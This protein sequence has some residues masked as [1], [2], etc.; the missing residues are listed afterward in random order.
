MSC[1]HKPYILALNYIFLCRKLCHVADMVE[2]RDCD[3]HHV[4]QIA[5]TWMLILSL[6]HHNS[7]HCDHQIESASLRQVSCWWKW[8]QFCQLAL[9]RSLLRCLSLSR[10]FSNTIKLDGFTASPA[11]IISGAT[12][13]CSVLFPATWLWFTCVKRSWIRYF[14]AP[15]SYKS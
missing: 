1:S 8:N 13:T 15:L 4:F 3:C 2:S 14:G 12:F 11:S 6:R 7:H 9:S 10:W 5:V